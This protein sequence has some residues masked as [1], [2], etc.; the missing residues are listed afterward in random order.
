MIKEVFL[1]FYQSAYCQW[2]EV[3]YSKPDILD[4]VI[5]FMDYHV[6]GKLWL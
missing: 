4:G 5:P 6:W 3:K 2:Q 1:D